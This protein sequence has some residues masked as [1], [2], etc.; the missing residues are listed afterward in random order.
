MYKRKF[1]D[2]FLCESELK[3]FVVPFPKEEDCQYDN[4]TDWR[5]S[6]FKFYVSV[7]SAWFA[8]LYFYSHSFPYYFLYILQFLAGNYNRIALKMYR[9]NE[10]NFFNRKFYFQ[11]SNLKLISTVSMWFHFSFESGSWKFWQNQTNWTHDTLRKPLIHVFQ[12]EI[13]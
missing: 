6:Q 4:I 11:E 7:S 3:A 5:K 1:A 8:S 9:W 10:N 2:C 13:W 12:V